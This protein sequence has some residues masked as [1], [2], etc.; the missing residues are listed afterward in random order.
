[1]THAE[2]LREFTRENGNIYRERLG[3]NAEETA[4]LLAGAEALERE[5]WRPMLTAW[6][7]TTIQLLMPDIAGY[8]SMPWNGCWSEVDYDW[9]LYAP[10]VGYD[11][12]RICVSK[13]PTP[14]GWKP[15]PAP[16]THFKPLPAPP[17]E[18]E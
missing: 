17:K 6:K 9:V 8:L 3:F 16:P 13:V 10:M 7:H 14:L 15:L 4:A 1:M 12:R 11:G 5:A 2:Q 18:D